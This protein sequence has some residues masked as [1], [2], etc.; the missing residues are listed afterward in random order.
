VFRFFLKLAIIFC[1]YF[2]A[3]R[4]IFLGFFSQKWEFSFSNLSLVML[5]GVHFDLMCFGYVSLPCFVLLG[6]QRFCSYSVANFLALTARIYL[7]LLALALG[8]VGF[9]DLLWFSQF[10]DRMNDAHTLQELI[11]AQNMNVLFYLAAAF[12][13][14]WAI[15]FALRLNRVSMDSTDS[16]TVL[17]GVCTL[18]FLAFI[19]RGSIGPQHLDLRDSKVSPSPFLN[20]AC[21]PSPYALDQAMRHRR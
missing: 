17:G 12:S 6:L 1:I 19:I 11:A 7:V 15:R 14:A 8:I 2:A 18:L 13:L 9:V 3:Q 4:L 21:V 20:L 16:P 5:T 10:G